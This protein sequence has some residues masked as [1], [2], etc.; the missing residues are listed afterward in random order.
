MAIISVGQ[1]YESIEGRDNYRTET[2]MIYRE[3]GLP[4]DIGKSKDN[5]KNRKP[6]YFN[7][8]IY[9]YIAK[10]CKKPKKER[11]TRKCYKYRQTGYIAKDCKTK[12]KIKNQSI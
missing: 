6:K 4:M 1:G 2:E 8:K 9:R 12:Q 5:F 11:D 3:Q 7:C 10:D